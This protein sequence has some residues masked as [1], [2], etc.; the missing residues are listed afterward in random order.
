MDAVALAAGELPHLL[1]LIGS[2]EVEL[3]A[4]GAARHLAPA[5]IDLVETAGNLLPDRL[6][7]RRRVAG[8][9]DI[10]QLHG[11]AE[12]QR[13]AIGLLL[14]SDHAE[15][16]SFAGTVGPDDADD[17]ARRQAEGE[18][19]HQELVAIGLAEVHRIDHE[20][21]ETRARGYHDLRGVRRL[22]PALRHQAVIGLDARLALRLAGA[23]AL[24]DPFQLVLEGTL[25]R[26]VRL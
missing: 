1:L 7:R 2:A 21:A 6:V 25:A 10:A 15:E 9:V 3:R 8:L 17:A 20:I 24:L 14:A 13:A 23:R 18:I 12:P 19:L 22:L 26:R 4:I 11:V 5:E 16:R